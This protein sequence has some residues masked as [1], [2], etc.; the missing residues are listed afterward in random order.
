MYIENKKNEE[1]RK[2][3]DKFKVENKDK[4][5]SIVNGEDINPEILQK[6]TPEEL[7]DK[8]KMLKQFSERKRLRSGIKAFDEVAN[9]IEKDEQEIEDNNQTMKKVENKG[10]TQKPRKKP[11]LRMRDDFKKYL[12]P[13]VDAGETY[14]P[15]KF[16]LMFFGSSMICKI[17]K[18]NR[19][20]NRKIVLF[21]GN[22]EGM[23]SYGI[24]I[25][26]QYADAYVKA[27]HELKRNLICIEW[28]P[29]H[30]FPQDI[31][32]RYHDFRFVAKSSKRPY[33]FCSPFLIK[34]FSMAGLRHLN[35]KTV[36]RK[37]KKLSKLFAFFKLTTNNKTPKH[38]AEEQAVK[39]RHLLSSRGLRSIHYGK[40]EL[41]GT[42]IQVKV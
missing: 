39:V 3:F 34:M 28:D 21:C 17:T 32:A 12:A 25:A 1:F 24:G 26:P 15:K 13:D 31:N 20:Y 10:I 37:N 35:F 41:K 38:L 33:W 16:N 30:T 2:F 14:D 19:I 22:G 27:Y 8:F 7:E 23:I 29:Q 40:K 6:E 42:R 9:E 18:L 4:W 11:L 36:S 5:A